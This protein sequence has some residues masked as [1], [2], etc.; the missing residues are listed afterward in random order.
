[1]WLDRALAIYRNAL[2][3]SSTTYVVS[4]TR[5][6]HFVRVLERQLASYEELCVFVNGALSE[7]RVIRGIDNTNENFIESMAFLERH[8]P[9]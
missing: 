4:S 8:R 1:M 5:A 9:S 6:R 7:R 3:S 2:H